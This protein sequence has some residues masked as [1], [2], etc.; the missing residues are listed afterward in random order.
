M[1][2]Y[3]PKDEFYEEG[4]SLAS[5]RYRVEIDEILQI[6]DKPDIDVDDDT[7]F[8]DY[9]SVASDK[10]FEELKEVINKLYGVE[11]NLEDCIWETAEKIHESQIS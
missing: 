10:G 5:E 2:N 11:V 7:Q 9:Y 1:N 6:M 3:F 8:W 4:I